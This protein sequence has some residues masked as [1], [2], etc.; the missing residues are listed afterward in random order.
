MKTMR[1]ENDCALPQPIKNVD[2][3]RFT[4]H[5][6]ALI[7][8]SDSK[9]ADDVNFLSSVPGRFPPDFS[10]FGAEKTAASLKVYSD[11]LGA[12]VRECSFTAGYMRVQKGFS[13]DFW[14]PLGREAAPAW[15]RRYETYKDRKLREQLFKVMEGMKRDR[16]DRRK[17][18]ARSTEVNTRFS[19]NNR[20]HRLPIDKSRARTTG[21][22][23]PASYTTQKTQPLPLRLRH[24]TLQ[25]SRN[26]KRNRPRRL[27]AIRHEN[28]P[29]NFA[30]WQFRRP[31]A[32]YLLPISIPMSY[33]T[34]PMQQLQH[35]ASG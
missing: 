4:R 19:K 35:R 24:T 25:L 31:R 21:R 3:L 33:K 5:Q 32:S 14:D 27:R 12:G 10:K 26:Q 16:R 8:D 22:P 11:S 29:S 34:D 7:A 13:V 2:E 1:F 20:K 17:V 9:H 23:T 15:R 28:R 6:K 30:N 18:K